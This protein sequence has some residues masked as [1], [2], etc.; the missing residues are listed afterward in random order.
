MIFLL[1]KLKPVIG[2][3]VRAGLEQTQ[4]IGQ[5]KTLENIN[6]NKG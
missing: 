5:D 3:S 6:P 2:V 1:T 4:D